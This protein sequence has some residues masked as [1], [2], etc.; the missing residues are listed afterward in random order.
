MTTKVGINGFG[1][2]GRLT[3]RTINQYHKGNLEIVAVNDLTDNK[4]NAH[5]LKWDSTFG[6]YKGT[7]EAV[8][9]GIM[10]DGQKVKVLAR[11]TPPKSPGKI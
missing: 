6:Q 5:L 9:D 1:R 7:V 10:I 3:L 11:K 2:I 8:A 4:T